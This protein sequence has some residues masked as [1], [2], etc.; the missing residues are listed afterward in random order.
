MLSFYGILMLFIKLVPLTVFAI[1]PGFTI[2]STSFLLYIPVVLLFVSCLS[3]NFESIES[4][5]FLIQ[6]IVYMGFVPFLAVSVVFMISSEV[7]NDY[8]LHLIFSF[9]SP[10]Y[11]PFGIIF[12]LSQ[13]YT[14]CMMEDN[15]YDQT[16]LD[17]M[18]E[19]QIY[20][21][22]VALLCHF[23]CWLC[24]LIIGDQIKDRKI[25]LIKALREQIFIFKEKNKVKKAK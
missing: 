24:L 17:W 2:I 11:I 12:Y 25:S 8:V 23:F 1:P 7:S 6:L 21:I 20:G 5:Q 14:K 10:F 9:L 22:Y 4:G 15:C 16:A 18:N 3:L 19:P 13:A